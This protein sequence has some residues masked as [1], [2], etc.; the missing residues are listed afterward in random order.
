MSI[1][2][3]SAATYE[4]GVDPEAVHPQTLRFLGRI[5]GD[6]EGMRAQVEDLSPA[7]AVSLSDQLIRIYHGDYFS[8]SDSLPAR[9]TAARR[10][11][12]ARRYVRGESPESI[13]EG[14]DYPP[15]I[16]EMHIDDIPRR[17]K[18][19]DEHHRIKLENIFN[20]TASEQY[21]EWLEA[22]E[23]YRQ[24]LFGDGDYTGEG[25]QGSLA[26]QALLVDFAR[27][28]PNKIEHL[29]FGTLTDQ[30]EV[31]LRAHNDLA[32][33]D[34]G[35]IFG[36]LGGAEGLS[37]VTAL[38]TRII[39]LW[40]RVI[41]NRNR[42]GVGTEPINSP[43]Q[44]L[45][46]AAESGVNFSR[47]DVRLVIE[48]AAS[49]TEILQSGYPASRSGTT[50]SVRIA[51]FI[52]KRGPAFAAD[53]INGVIVRE[54]CAKNGY[55]ADEW[56]R[57]FTRGKL[58]QTA[59]E[60][61][62]PLSAVERKVE[63]FQKTLSYENLAVIT[64]MGLEEAQD[65]FSFKIRSD[66]ATNRSANP[67][68]VVRNLMVCVN[69]TLSDQALMK[70]YGRTFPE[71]LRLMAAYVRPV[72]PW[73]YLDRIVEHLNNPAL[74]TASL[75][76][77]LGWSP[78]E[79]KALFTPTYIMRIASTTKDNLEA[80]IGRV[81]YNY[82][83]VLS[84]ANLAEELRISQERTVVL[85]S[86]YRRKQLALRVD[87]I[88][89]ARRFMGT[90][91]ELV[92]AGLESRNPDRL[93]AEIAT[94]YRRAGAMKLFQV[95]QTERPADVKAGGMWNRSILRYPH[96]S[97][98]VRRQ[99]VAKGLLRFSSLGSQISLDETRTSSGEVRSSRH[100]YMRYE[101][102]MAK[103]PGEL[104]T[105]SDL[106]EQLQGI[107]EQAG[108]T[109]EELTQLL[110]GAIDFQDPVALVAHTKLGPI[111]DK[112]RRAADGSS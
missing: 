77:T 39:W 104:L 44:R 112:M 41:A 46:V 28:R 86:E 2:V 92:E 24:L 47:T 1:E 34:T 76:K 49:V 23:G 60:Y 91:T 42:N 3:A 73:R 105:P 14:T 63:H 25:G 74:Q 85:F 4:H 95:M 40:E 6:D 98:E 103:D 54:Y 52:A 78:G 27:L 80:E 21:E 10:A 106:L 72:N 107:A 58:A 89:S 69:E 111:L 53:W 37:H 71:R 62:D 110:N 12:M 79:V 48:T 61:A 15:S 33:E 45:S 50:N 31:I 18:K 102:D 82:K 101:G 75:V 81:S 59:I 87:P 100:D 90:V 22:R 84:T 57:V 36:L 97:E 56:L 94:Y 65:F 96:G 66:I 109:S 32:I 5:A 20:E 108:V 9:A 43:F 88:E 30:V 38:T 35:A 55:D 64:G 13:A 93:A 70:R 99:W 68:Q 8:K 19:A 16:V 11:D 51:S 29:L 26:G 83:T 67:E 7:L 17:L